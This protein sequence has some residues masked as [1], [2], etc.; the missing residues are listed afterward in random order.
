MRLLSPGRKRILTFAA[1]GVTCFLVQFALLSIMVRFGL[2]RPLANAVSFAISAQLNFLL[3]TRITWR[4]RPS[5]GRHG[6]TA[7]WVA[8]NG[9]ALA[10]LG[11]NTAVF[12]LAY[13][14]IGTTPAAMLG[15]MT[16]TC[17]VYLVCNLLVFRGAAPVVTSMAAASGVSRRP[18]AMELDEKAVR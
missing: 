1:I 14:A 12:V 17:L 18:V 6:T 4:D 8:Y 7:R 5:A 3:S 11:G 13:H 2:Y 15:V 9:T 16:G 10:S